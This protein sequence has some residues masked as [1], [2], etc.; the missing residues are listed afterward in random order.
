[1]LKG[2]TGLDA[3]DYMNNEAITLQVPLRS[4]SWDPLGVVQG[5]SVA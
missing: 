1:M 2:V 4:E 3:L 5:R